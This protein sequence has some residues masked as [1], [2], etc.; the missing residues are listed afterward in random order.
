M[1][2]PCMQALRFS[3]PGA[4]GN[5][6]VLTYATGGNLVHALL[7]HRPELHSGVSRIS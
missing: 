5:P 1:I 6:L 2:L 3:V 4:K 7:Q